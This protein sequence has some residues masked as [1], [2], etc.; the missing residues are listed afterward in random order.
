MSGCD[1]CIGGHDY[2]GFIEFYDSKV[3]K[4]RKSH[5]C[6]ECRGEIKIGESYE[7]ASGKCEGQIWQAHTCEPCA[8]IRTVFSCGGPQVHGELWQDFEDA[9]V[10]ERLTTASE[11]FTQLSPKSK[12]FLLDRWRKWKGLKK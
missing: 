2:D 6:I 8:E 12:A 11:C 3:V 9:D 7:Y 1:V 4:A 5:T 10:F